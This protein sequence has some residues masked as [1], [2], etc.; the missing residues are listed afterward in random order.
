MATKPKEFSVRGFALSDCIVW[1]GDSGGGL[2]NTE[3][4]LIGIVSGSYKYTRS[5]FVPASVI[6]TS[7]VSFTI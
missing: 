6:E 5:V 7:W 2:F 4:K 1:P 3:N